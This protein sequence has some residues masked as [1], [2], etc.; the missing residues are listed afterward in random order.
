MLALAVVVGALAFLSGIAAVVLLFSVSADPHRRLFELNAYGGTAA[1]TLVLGGILV[2][3][4]ASALG[5]TGSSPMPPRLAS[6]PWLIAAALAFP[7]LI[8]LGQLQVSHPGAVPWLFPLTN[9]GIVSLPSAFIALIVARR[10]QRFNAFAWP[11]S[12]REWTTGFI[13]G[14][15]GATTVAAAINT[16]YVVFAGALLIH[17][18]GSGDAFH[19]TR[20]LPSVPRPWG[21]AFDLSA[22]S[23][24]APLNEE[25][26]KGMLV[27]LFFFRKGGPAR[28]FLWGVLAG[29]GFNL[30]ETFQNSLSVLSPD[31]VTAREIG[32]QWW[33]FAAARGGTAAI[34]ACA[35]GFSALGVY[36]VL[37]RKPKFVL[38]Y[39]AGVSIHAAW[40]LLN[41]PLSGDAFYSQAGPRSAALDVV[42]IIGL[43]ALF[44]VCAVLLWQVPRR[45]RDGLPAPLYRAIGMLPGESPGEMGAL[46]L[47][48]SAGTSQPSA[49]G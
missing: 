49:G 40:N 31:L 7:T 20:N 26:W 2:Y 30:L 35:A 8:V 27:A 19:I 10:Y 37:R 24:V 42:S 9:L 48:T 17:L 13:Y 33:L 18:E 22:L 6:P 28:C 32:S 46:R 14:A 5:N 47:V 23:V 12:W 21:I 36:G 3:Q 11:V 15:V 29:A 25:F 39:P 4:A 41:Y 45:L 16:A 1:V 44:S 38:G 34:H 43:F